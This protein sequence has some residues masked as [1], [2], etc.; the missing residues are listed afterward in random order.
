MLDTF[1]F[2]DRVIFIFHR[3]HALKYFQT[4]EEVYEE[5]EN[6]DSAKPDFKPIP[7]NGT[8][9]VATNNGYIVGGENTVRGEIPFLAALGRFIA[10]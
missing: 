4:I 1:I 6:P 7:G 5:P 3:M 10:L 9:G 8:C 2:D